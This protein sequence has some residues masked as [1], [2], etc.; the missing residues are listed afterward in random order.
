MVES[1]M[2]RLHLWPFTF[3]LALVRMDTGASL[4][5]GIYLW[6]LALHGSIAALD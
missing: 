5:V 6:K 2:W 4:T 3:H 1:R